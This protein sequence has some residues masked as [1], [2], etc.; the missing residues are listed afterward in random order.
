MNNCRKQ[1]L[2]WNAEFITEFVI[3][4]KTFD[5]FEAAYNELTEKLKPQ[6]Y[7]YGFLNG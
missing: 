6:V 3:Y 2:K 1:H 7:Y 5:D 4:A